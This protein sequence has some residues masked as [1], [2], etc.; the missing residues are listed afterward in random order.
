MN[1][2]L[3]NRKRRKRPD[4]EDMVWAIKMLMMSDKE[5]ERMVNNFRD[6]VIEY[7]K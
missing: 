7:N 2:R 1:I 5:I 4:V 6:A 3:F